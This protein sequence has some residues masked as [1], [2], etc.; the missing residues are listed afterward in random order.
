M[1]LAEIAAVLRV[2]VG[3]V[4]AQLFRATSKVKEAVKEKPC[5]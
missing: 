4:K 2:K 5:G 3:T 1:S